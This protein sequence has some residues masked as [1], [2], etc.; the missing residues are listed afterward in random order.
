MTTVKEI[1]GSERCCTLYVG[2]RSVGQG[3]LV[4]VADF[5]ILVEP[6][7]ESVVGLMVDSVVGFVAGLLLELVVGLVFEVVDGLEG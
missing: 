7:V 1:V 2:G 6:L 3:V 5:E 4:T